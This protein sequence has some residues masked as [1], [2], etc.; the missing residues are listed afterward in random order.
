MPN[1]LLVYKGGTMAQTEKEQQAV[2]AAWGNWFGELGPAVVDGG[3][4]FGPSKSVATHGAVKDGGASALTGY[5]ILK[6][7]S[8]DAAAKLA[9]GCPVLTS[10]GT[11]EVYETI[12]ID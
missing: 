4:P 7:D 1:Y 9:K 6:A 3:A 11:L 5:S 12:K 2:M 10:G 8:L